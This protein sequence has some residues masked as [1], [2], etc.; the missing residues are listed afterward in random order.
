MKMCFPICRGSVSGAGI[1]LAFSLL[2]GCGIGQLPFL[3]HFRI[4]G[5]GVDAWNQWRADYPTVLPTIANLDLSG[6]DLRGV[7]FSHVDLF[8]TDLSFANLEDADLTDSYLDEAKFVNANLVSANLSGALLRLTDFTR[9]DLG[10]ANLSEVLGWEEIQSIV[11][12]NI[13]GIENAPDGFREW[14]LSNGAVE[15]ESP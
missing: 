9:A 15:V 8:G 11:D 2:V 3:A 6:R 12:C 14:A 4:L 1:L 10:G 13:F 5:N 7:N